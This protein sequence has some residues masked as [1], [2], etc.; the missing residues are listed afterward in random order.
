MPRL[1]NDAFGSNATP[2][3][4]VPPFV[5]STN[6]VAVT[7]LVTTGVPSN[8]SAP[9]SGAVPPPFTDPGGPG[10]VSLSMSTATPVPPAPPDSRNVVVAAGMCRS[11]AVVNDATTFSAGV[12]GFPVKAVLN[13]LRVV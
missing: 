7:S 9:T 8:S 1:L 5:G 2:T 11:V 13:A 3:L 12:L 4:F 6:A 10:R